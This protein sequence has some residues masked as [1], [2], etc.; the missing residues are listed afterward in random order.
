MWYLNLAANPEVQLQVGPEVF[1]AHARTATKTEK[2]HLW[3]LMTSILP[4]YDRYQSR[5]S[6][7]IPVVILERS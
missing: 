3:E 2:P 1:Y 5:T 7:D 4:E 6:R